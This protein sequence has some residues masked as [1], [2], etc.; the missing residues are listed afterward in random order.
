MLLAH[1]LFK[2]ALFLVVGIVDHATG[3]R[4]LRRAVRA[5]PA[6]P[7][8]AAIGRARRASM[9]GLPPLLGFVGKEA[10]FEALSTAAG[11]PDRLR[12]ARRRWSLGSVLTVA[13][14]LRFLWGAFATQARRADRAPTARHRPTAPFLA[15]PAVL[16]L[17]GLVARRRSPP[18]LEPAARGRTP[19]RSG[20]RRRAEKLAALARPQPAL[21]AVGAGAGS[22][23]PRCSWA[24]GAGRRWQRRLAVGASRR[25]GLPERPSSG[26]DRLAVEVTGATQRGS[27]PVYLGTILRRRAGAARHAAGH[28]RARGPTS[29]GSGT[30]RCRPLVGA[31][32]RD[33]GGLRRSG[34]GAG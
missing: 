18:A 10:A 23:A 8:L 12:R 2:A 26:L 19:T 25:R 3:T 1:A 31:R 33:R 4:D 28:R 15:P 16:A 29:G 32:R 14:T 11:R 20:R 17:A 27:L 21:G 30:P 9:A 6:A 34:P 24:R 22:A 5:R 13:Y 7:A